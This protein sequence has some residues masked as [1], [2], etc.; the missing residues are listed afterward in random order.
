MHAKGRLDGGTLVVR[1]PM[2]LGRQRGH[3]RLLAPD[4]SELT[5]STK[6]Q[7]D[8]VLVKALA[9][10]WRHR[11]PCRCE[12][13][14][15]NQERS[16]EPAE[17]CSADR[18]AGGGA[19]PVGLGSFCYPPDYASGLTKM[20]GRAQGAASRRLPSLALPGRA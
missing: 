2:R 8:G 4:G 20:L 9:R 1:I 5:P 15:A 17:P 6:P 3:K 7:P 13:L 10:A 16:C 14:G 11:E 19:G 12:L 18:A